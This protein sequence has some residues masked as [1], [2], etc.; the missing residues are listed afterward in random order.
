MC[1]KKEILKWSKKAERGIL[2]GY[3]S[4][5]KGYRVYIP[6]TME[7]S[8]TSRDVVIIEKPRAAESVVVIEE[9][10]QILLRCMR[11]QWGR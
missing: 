2:V 1:P 8:T 7:V 11:M 4:D 6:K 3:P 9:N 5:V 10:Q